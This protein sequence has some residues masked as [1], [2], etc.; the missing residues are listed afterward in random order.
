M[1]APAPAPSS[2][3]SPVPVNDK[4]ALLCSA[5]VGL[6]FGLMFAVRSGYSYGATLLLLMS[7][8]YAFAPSCRHY[9]GT[10]ALS[11]D[12][13]AVMGALLAY[14]VVALA[15][16]AG[17]GNDFNDL[18]QPLR[19]A[20]TVPVVWMLL[21][22]SYDLRALWGGVTAGVALS[23]AIAWWQLHVQ[24]L[25]RAEGYL[26]II[27]FGNIAL[28]FGAMCAAGLQWAAA[29]DGRRRTSWWI[30]FA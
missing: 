28:V 6:F 17:L 25:D 14:F 1:R 9:R 10:T 22:V 8:W 11:A 2:A 15:A 23:V 19:A 5:G 20:L 29:L 26:N 27:H 18:D 24:G 21:R 3:F 12:D 16:T 7:V 4:H 13:R 30:A